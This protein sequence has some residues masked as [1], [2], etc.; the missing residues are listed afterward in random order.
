MAKPW[1]PT[2]LDEITPA[3]LTGVLRAGGVLREAEVSGVETELLGEGEGFVGCIARLSLQFE[4]PEP[5]APATLIAKLPTS[6]PA[7]RAAGEM[8]GLYEREILFY[9][10]LAP[11]VAI[12]TPRLYHAEM[13]PNP[14]AERSP[15]F[16]D[17][18]ERLPRWLLA[19]LM[20]LFELL[21]RLRRRRYL[22]L[23][24]DLAPARLGD[25]VAGCDPA[26]AASALRALARVHA[27]LWNSS[28]LRGRFWLLGYG[29]VPRLWHRAFRKGRRTFSQRHLPKMAASVSGK[30]DWLEHHGIELSRAFQDGAPETLLHTD[31]RLDNL[32]FGAGEAAGVCAIDWQGT[33]RGPGVLDAAY[34][35]AGS[36]AP[37]LPEATIH[38]LLAA[39][40]AELVARGVEGYGLEVCR[41]DYERALLMILYRFVTIDS[42]DLGEE[43]G[44]ELLDAWMRRLDA[45]LA[46]V[47]PGRALGS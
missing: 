24:E 42:I 7:N 8:L 11:R 40:H 1:I 17:F 38:E 9:R 27:D 28:E 6:V 41:R 5:G 32:F 12:R 16:L 20:P 45:R 36:L 2:R 4:P 29:T 26:T 10:E 14:A 19:L 13:D 43:R 31:Y 44:A 47:D 37:E 3:W 21:A 25:Q 34:F 23:I 18:L 33:A 35:L 39:Y 46:A 15:E 22:M 30:L